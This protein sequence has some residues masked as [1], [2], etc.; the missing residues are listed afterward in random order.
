MNRR[1]FLQGSA[2]LFCAPAIVRAESL[3]KIWV[4]DNE[5]ILP[6]QRDIYLGDEW[7]Y[8]MPKR[9]KFTNAYEQAVYEMVRGGHWVETRRMPMGY[10]R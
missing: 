10:P 1:Q 7:V 9:N 4:P 8:H 5:I 6:S 2:A 3:M